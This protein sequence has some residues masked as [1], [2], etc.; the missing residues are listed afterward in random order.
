D[1]PVV[2]VNGFVECP[3]CGT[4]VNCGTA[5]LANLVQHQGKGPCQ[6]ARAKRDK[7]SKKK[8]NTS[9][10]TFLKPKPK[11]I[12]STF[13]HSQP[14]H[15]QKLPPMASPAIL[16]QSPVSLTP[17]AST[18]ASIS[19]PAPSRSRLL[20]KLEHF[21]ENLPDTIPEGNE[22]DKLAYFAG[23]PADYDTPSLNADDLWEESLNNRLKSVFGWGAEEDI[24]NLLR[25]GRYGLDGLANFVKY[26]VVKRGVDEALFEG[27]LSCLMNELEEVYEGRCSPINIS[28]T[29]RATPVP[30]AATTS[31]AISNTP[32][33]SVRTPSNTEPLVVEV[34]DVDSFESTPKNCVKPAK[35]LAHSCQGYVLV[36]PDG[37]SPHTCYPFAL[38]D[39]LILPWDYIVRNS[40]M[41]LF[42]S[43]C[44]GKLEGTLK[45][46]RACS[47]LAKN[48]TLE[49]M[50]ERIKLGV[51]ENA[52]FA[53]HGFGGLH[54]LLHK[55]TMQI[56]FHRF[57][58]LN[59]AKKLLSKATALSHQKRLIMAIASGKVNQI[60]RLLSIGLQQKRGIR[61]LLSL[62][63]AAADGVYSPK[64]FT[65][66]E[67][68]KSML[69]WR[70]GGN[71][72][73]EI[74][75]RSKDEPS[76]TY[77]RSHSDVP[78]L[79]PSPAQPT[80]QQVQKNV[81]ASLGGIL[82]EIHSCTSGKVLHTVV[83]FDELAT[84]KRIRWDPKTNYFLGVC[85]EHGHKT[86]M[87]FVNEGDME[88]LF[89]LIDNGKVHHAKEATVGALGILCKDNRIYPGRPVLVSGDCK[90][91]TGEEHA[92]VIQTVLDGVNTSQEKTKLRITSISSD[93]ESRRGTAFIDL[94]FKRVLLPRSPIYPL[95]HPLKFLD[96][97]VGDD[98]L[99]C[100]KD[101][102]HVFKRF[103]NLF[104]RE[105]G[106]VVVGRRITPNIMMT[107]FKSEGLTAEHIRSLFNPEDAQDVKMAYDMLKDIWN[108]PRL[109]MQV[110]LKSPGFL[111]TREALWLLGKLLFHLI[112]PYLCVDLSLSEQ[113]EHL[114][115]AAH[116]ALALYRMAGKDFIPT[117]LYI[118]VM[119]MIKNTFFCVAKAKIDDPEGEFWIIL[120]GTDRLEELFGILRT[121][122]GN[123][124]NLDIYQLIGRIAGTTEVSNIL[125]KY[126]HWDR[127]PRRLKLPSLT[128]DTKEI[129]DRADHIKPASWRGNV[130]VKNVS[131]QTSWNRGRNIIEQDSAVIK[132]VLLELD[133][134]EDVDMLS[135]F[136]ILLVDAP[137]AEDDIDES[138]EFL[139]SLATGKNDEPVNQEIQNGSDTN[140][141]LEVETALGELTT[142]LPE[143]PNFHKDVT[144]RGT[145]TSK[146]RALARFIKDRKRHGPGSTDRLRRVQDV[147]RH[148]TS[149]KFDDELA[150][151]AA[152]DDSEVLFTLDPVS[153]LVRCEN[154]LWLAIGEVTSIKVDG[155]SVTYVN[156]DM[157]EEDTV[158]VSYQM[159][160]LRPATSDDDLEGKHDW[161]TYA[162]DEKTH[163]VPGRMIQPINPTV[164]KVLTGHP[165]YLLESAMLMALTAS[166]FQNLTKSYLKSVPKMT[167]SKE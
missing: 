27:K 136:G 115:A 99:T 57:R 24:K 162:I 131:L 15:S 154:Q 128:R 141:R 83:M 37:K 156:L 48:E 166:L 149:K 111:Q 42:S 163:T 94:T 35:K 165:F 85:R 118:D 112:F 116:L 109:D 160:G 8:K 25:R 7:E 77:L 105:R 100:D 20:A 133:N 55:K 60:D 9:I 2:G 152:T 164:S 129:P 38:H 125:A 58:S 104:V 56:K 61:G 17:K 88:E 3:E 26:F 167:P 43:S 107:H 126:P 119:L 98:D 102:K 95:L 137:L 153:S 87:E 138:L 142:K 11:P 70:L 86:S 40:T 32:A 23:N 16:T 14:I 124:A 52:T 93:G 74:N 147:E 30:P 64:S 12:P 157:L 117:N 143:I 139:P 41:T 150:A 155:R 81:E 145:R 89:R 36:F 101:Y 140:M 13:H 82:K 51:H 21:I 65:E 33:T 68:M 54:D 10:F 69:A 91:E 4:S 22:Y 39:T 46:C 121:M 151:P 28:V 18:S 106:V 49:Q 71:R 161:R 120:L 132:S 146:A 130:K 79:V 122:V 50:K 92:K 148:P 78:L 127:S 5:G 53:Y 114:S 47:G 62:Y 66:E 108:L 84:E 31:M 96:L 72:I 59:Q 90:I 73:A 29:N 103:R 44:R 19:V 45:S 97:H 67:A 144:F 75:H 80:I 159:L 110:S 158:T 6:K 123:D 63:F 135:P 34:I 113:L 1:A 76:L 134:S